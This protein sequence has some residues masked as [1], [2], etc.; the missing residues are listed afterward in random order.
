MTSP[1][2]ARLSA[3]ALIVLASP[4]SLVGAQSTFPPIS[5]RQFTGGSLKVKVTGSFSIDE[6]V[7][8]NT[9][10]SFGDGEMTWLQFGISGAT[11]P[12]AL[13][14]FTDMKETGITVG[15]GK[16]IATGGIAPGEKSLC[17]GK[18][19]VTAKL[20]TG[21]YTCRGI[22]SHDAQT[23]KLGKVDIDVSFTARS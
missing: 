7:G 4:L 16:L 2:A 13:M 23:S 17:A 6:E 15:R 9:K 1:L 22:Q 8:I 21:H 12:N 14:T 11:E 10:A 19:E 3:F 20:I 5:A 18:V